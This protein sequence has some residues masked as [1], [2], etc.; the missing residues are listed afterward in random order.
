MLNELF[1]FTSDQDRILVEPIIDNYLSIGRYTP[2]KENNI[3]L[4]WKNINEISNFNKR[5]HLMAVSLALP[6][7]TTIDNYVNNIYNNTSSKDE[8]TLG[9]FYIL[10]A[11][12]RVSYDCATSLPWLA[13][14]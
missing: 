12:S 13:D 8:H 1:I 14:F 11:L 5:Y 9:S 3:K 4:K 7:D 2:Q 10:S 6:M